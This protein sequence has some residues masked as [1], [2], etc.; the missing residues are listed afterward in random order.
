[1]KGRNLSR[2][3]RV[4]IA[5]RNDAMEMPMPTTLPPRPPQPKLEPETL[6]LMLASLMLLFVLALVCHKFYPNL[7]GY[8]QLSS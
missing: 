2:A 6:A 1:M 5:Y 4:F 3:S 8:L 7:P